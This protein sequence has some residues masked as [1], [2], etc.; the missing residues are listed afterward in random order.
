MSQLY[1]QPIWG[2][3]TAD[4]S[5]A[6]LAAPSTSGHGVDISTWKKDVTPIGY[7]AAVIL[8]DG[9]GTITLTGPVI[10]YGYDGGTGGT[11]KWRKIGQLFAAAN[12]V[13]TSTVG[14]AETINFPAVFTRICISAAVSA[15]NVSYRLLPLALHNG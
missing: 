2:L 14:Y 7:Q 13:L 8:I 12:I 11:S 1:A 15:N 9:D 4:N 6:A 10:L 5:A 3:L